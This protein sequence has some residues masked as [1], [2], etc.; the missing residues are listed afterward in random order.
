[1]PD[2]FADSLDT[3]DDELWDHLADADWAQHDPGVA[4]EFGGLWVVAH[5]RRVIAS[6][7]D[8]ERVRQDAGGRI[9]LPLERILVTA[10]PRSDDLLAHA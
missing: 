3:P 7:E 6:G 4:Q 8:P 2:T 10:V 5:K 9:G 1:M